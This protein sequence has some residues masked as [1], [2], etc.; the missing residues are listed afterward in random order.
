M[1]LDTNV[2]TYIATRG[3]I[4]ALDDLAREWSLDVVVP[5]SVLLEAMRTRDRERL[6]QL[7]AAVTRRFART[8]HPPTE[9]QQA[10]DEVV[11]AIRTLRPHWLRAFPEASNITRLEKFWTKRLWQQ[12]AADPISV[13]ERINAGSEMDIAG[14]QVFETQK[15]NRIAFR[16]SGASPT[17]EIE[18]HVDLSNQLD[19]ERLAWEGERIAFWRVDNSTTWWAVALHGATGRVPLHDTLHDWLDPW[20]RAD[21][22]RGDRESWNRFWYYEVDGASMPRTWI[23]SLMP[24]AQILTKLGEGNPRDVQHAAYLYDAD[25]FFTADRRYAAALEHL[26][27]WSPAP[28]ART[29]RLVATESV[30]PGIKDELERVASA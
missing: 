16:E 23:T 2:W 12:A 30:V 8:T 6:A 7:V 18:P 24:W 19:N 11:S 22:I 10:A 26:R 14:E 29:V 25:I 20:I 1:V 9:A 4:D 3:E 5:P 27:P 21:L 15:F 17:W 28:F 13:A